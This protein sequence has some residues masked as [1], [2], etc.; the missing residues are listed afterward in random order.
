MITNIMKKIRRI[1]H[2]KSR[3]S[4]EEGSRTRDK[5]YL[6]VITELILIEVSKAQKKEIWSLL[7]KIISCNMCHKM[8]WY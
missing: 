7:Y 3:M 4:V 8:S 5:G 2:K 6:M 1:N